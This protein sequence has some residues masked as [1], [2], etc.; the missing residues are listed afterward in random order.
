MAELLSPD[1]LLSL[2]EYTNIRDDFRRNIMV[3][4]RARR[5]PVGTNCTAHIENRDTMRYQVLEMLRAEGTWDKPEAVAEELHAYNP[6]ISQPEMLSVTFMFEYPSEEERKSELPKL[7]GIDQH[8]WFQIGD[9]APILGAFDAGQI[10]EDKVSSVQFVKFPISPDQR[11]RMGDADTVLRIVIDHPH[12][13]GQAVL[14]EDT[15]RSIVAD[16]TP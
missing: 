16:L 15:R 11:N 2:E 8:V 1:D 13:Q 4:K 7:V 10:D 5:V 12:Y 14:G 3:Q 9:D 6:L